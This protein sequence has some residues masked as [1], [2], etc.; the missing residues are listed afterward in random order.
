[1]A[2]QMLTLLNHTIAIVEAFEQEI[3]AL[4]NEQPTEWDMKLNGLK[5]DEA[6]KLLTIVQTERNTLS[7][8]VR[9]FASEGRIDPC[10]ETAELE[11]MKEM[12]E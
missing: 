1:M 11:M 5:L 4:K 6:K 2:T 9:I 12:H 3:I 8:V 7:Q 10:K